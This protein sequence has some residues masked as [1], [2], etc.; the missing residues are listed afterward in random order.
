MVIYLDER[1]GGH[2]KSV[3]FQIYFEGCTNRTFWQPGYE[4]QEKESEDDAKMSQ[5]FFLLLRN[6][7]G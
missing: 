6:L 1:S 5:R 3:G 2:E 4:E 7:K